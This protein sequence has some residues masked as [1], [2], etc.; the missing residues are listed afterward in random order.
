MIS[1]RSD[2]LAKHVFLSSDEHEGFFT[3]NY[4]H[5]L[6]GQTVEIEFQSE[7][8][9]ELEEFKQNLAVRSLVDAFTVKAGL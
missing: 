9:I 7:E 6:P 3:E 2:K 1:L 4:F 8:R 5:L